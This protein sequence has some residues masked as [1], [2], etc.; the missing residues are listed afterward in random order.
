MNID[1]RVWFYLSSLKIQE[2]FPYLSPQAVKTILSHLI[3]NG[4]LIKDHKGEG[5][6]KFDRTTWYS[7]TDKAIQLFHLRI[8]TNGE[9]EN[10][11]I[12]NNRSYNTSS[13]EES[14]IVNIGKRFIKPSIEEIRAYCLERGNSVDAETFHDFYESKGWRIG[15]N[16]MKDW[17]AAV[18]TWEKPRENKTT[19]VARQP[20]RQRNTT[21]D[22]LA[23]GREM[24]GPQNH[25]CD[26]Q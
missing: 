7:L 6:D 22:L 11:H 25:S 20:F 9:A 21:E 12:V 13:N 16:P 14:N 17:R 18:R 4:F 24:F 26:E 1:G 2:V 15:N 10:N 8:S 5:Q 23:L 3:E 19:S